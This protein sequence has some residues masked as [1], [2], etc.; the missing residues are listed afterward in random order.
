MKIAVTGMRGI[1]SSF[2][3]AEKHSE[4]LYTRLKRMG[5]DITI[6]ARSGYLEDNI[7]EFEGIKIKQISTLNT[8]HSEAILHTF[9]SIVDVLINDKPDILHIHSIGPSFLSFLP[10]LKHIK[11]VSTCHGLDW[12]REKWSKFAKLCL[13]QGE[14]NAARYAD[15]VICV[16]KTLSSYFNDK[17]AI[18][19]AYI[20]N[21]VNIPEKF[22]PEIITQNHRLTK[23]SYF[24]FTGRLV[25]EKGIHYL[26]EA[27]KKTDTDKKLV[28]TGGSSHSDEYV[29][30]LKELAGDDGR[31]IFT[32]Y[33]YGRELA[34]LYSNTYCYVIPSDL[35]GLPIALLEAL[36]YGIP[37]IASD[38]APNVEVIQENRKYGL[39]FK[40]GDVEQLKDAME[41]A[42]NNS[43]EINNMGQKALQHVKD[44]YDWDSVATE[45][46]KLYNT[47]IN[48]K[49]KKR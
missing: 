41:Y 32:G 31:I 26:I 8:K 34:E 49:I 28:I 27:F 38:I 40:Q 16:S 39:I 6:Y 9:K 2:G 5:C 24:L 48:G 12:Q 13:R 22:A 43:E 46:F 20:P 7:T 14:K 45:T 11:V 30:K 47:I 36:S 23:D 10:R 33:C 29:Q 44:N 1:P 17:Y 42:L 19:S 37:V 4:E 15:K 18:E 21:G 35:E 3:G 25:P